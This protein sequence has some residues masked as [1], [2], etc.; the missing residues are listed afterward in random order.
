M[1]SRFR[2]ARWILAFTVLA[3]GAYMTA[4]PARAQATIDPDAR[5]VLTSMS[6][7]LGGLKSFSVDY[8]AVDEVVTREGQK[9]QFLHSGTITV[10]RPDR[11]HAIR[12]GAAGVAELF[13]DGKHLILSSK[14]AGAYLQ[15]DASSIDSAVD[16][17]HNFG[18]DAPGA[19]LLVSKP[20]DSSQT[21]MSSGV[22]VG[23]TYIDGVKVHQLA[24]RGTDVDWQLWV[25]DGDR[26]LPV[27]YVITTKGM[28]G[29]PE[30]TLQ[31]THWNTAPPTDPAQFTFVPTADAKK[32][33]PTAVTVNATDDLVIKGK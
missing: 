31:L 24:F 1:L 5:S 25:T 28:S 4:P 18:F 14:D 32:L 15:F 26:R 33:D 9:L 7:Y 23:M 21:D 30:F 16:V 13:L 3:T 19:D 12:R 29:A 8:T 20:L 10:Q 27:R 6:G 2:F 22:H 11:L 17:V